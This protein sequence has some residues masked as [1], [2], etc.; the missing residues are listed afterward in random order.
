MSVCLSARPSVDGLN[1]IDI[2]QM[3][4]NLY[5]LFISDIERTVFKII[6]MAI[7]ARLQSRTKIF[8]CI[9]AYRGEG[10]VCKVYCNI[11]I[12]HEMQRN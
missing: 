3:S 10:K 8:R 12:L 7:S 9:S 1:V 11:F 2:L 4:L 5:M 6:C